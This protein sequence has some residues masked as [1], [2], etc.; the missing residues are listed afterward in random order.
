MLFL[1]PAIQSQRCLC[2]TLYF[3]PDVKFVIRKSVKLYPTTFRSVLWECVSMC[4]CGNN[5]GATLQPGDEKQ[6]HS[7]IPV[8]LGSIIKK[9]EN[10]TQLMQPSGITYTKFNL[11]F[12]KYL[13]FCLPCRRMP[14]SAEGCLAQVY[15]AFCHQEGSGYLLTQTIWLRHIPFR[16]TTT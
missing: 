3:A 6:G 1:L 13:T 14:C 4:Y 10:S 16:F 8:F 12:Q 2:S 9:I 15:K 5:N 7:N 11:S